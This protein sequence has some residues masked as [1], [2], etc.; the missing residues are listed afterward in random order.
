M[1]FCDG[2][3][4][5]IPVTANGVGAN[6]DGKYIGREQETPYGNVVLD[7]LNTSAMKIRKTEL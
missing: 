4:E 1:G 2:L 6:G 5:H 3:E 7:I